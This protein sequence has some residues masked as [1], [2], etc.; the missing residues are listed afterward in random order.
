MFI[1]TAR[2]GESM[3][4]IDFTYPNTN[5]NGWQVNVLRETKSNHLR[6]KEMKFKTKNEAFAYYEHI[7]CM[8]QHQNKSR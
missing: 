6:L 4:I 8:W 2:K 5:T 1:A 7:R 3:P